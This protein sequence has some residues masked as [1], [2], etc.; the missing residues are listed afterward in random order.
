M[1]ITFLDNT[2]KVELQE[3]ITNG[4]D[5]VITSKNLLEFAKLYEGYNYT[6]ANGATKDS[7]YDYF[8]LTLPAYTYKTN[9]NV[10]RVVSLELNKR[11]DSNQIFTLTKDT[12]I[13]VVRPTGE[14]AKVFKQEYTAAEVE[15]FGSV[16][17]KDS[18]LTPKIDEQLSNMTGELQEQTSEKIINNITKIATSNNLLEFAELIEGYSYNPDNGGNVANT[19]RSYYK[20]KLAADTYVINYCMSCYNITTNEWIFDSQVS[21]KAEF[22][23]ESESEIIVNKINTQTNMKLFSGTMTS[24]LPSE[25]ESLGT[26]TLSD[27]I[28]TPKIDEQF[29]N[30]ESDL[31]SL[32]ADNDTNDYL[33]KNVVTSKNLLN[34]IKPVEGYRHNATGEVADSSC[35][36]Y[37][38]KLATGNY[39]IAPQCYS[40]F[41]VTTSTA[42]FSTTTAGTNKNFI[43]Y[44]DSESEIVVNRYLSYDLKLYK[45]NDAVTEDTTI[46]ITPNEVESLGQFTLPNKTLIPNITEE[47]NDNV[48]KIVTSKNLLEFIKPVE[49]YRYTL[50]TIQENP[51]INY[52]RVKLP[53][54]N[55]EFNVNINSCLNLTNYGWIITSTN[56]GAGVKTFSLTEDAEV[57]INYDKN[58]K[59]ILFNSD[60][61]SLADVE[62][63]GT[64][65]LANTVIIP[66]FDY[67]KYIDSTNYYSDYNKTTG[68]CTWSTDTALPILYLGTEVNS[69]NCKDAVLDTDV[70]EVT[71]T[72]KFINNNVLKPEFS[73]IGENGDITCSVKWQGSSSIKYPKK[74]YTIKFDTAFELVDGWGTEKKYC[75]KANFID[76]SQSRNIVAAGLW[77]EVV[78]SRSDKDTEGTLSN[79]LSQLP[80]GGAVDGFPFILV[81]GDEYKG[82]YTFNIPKDGW[83]FGMGDGEQECILCAENHL[84][85]EKFKATITASDAEV[86]ITKDDIENH[87][88]IEYNSDSFATVDIATSL[89]NLLGKCIDANT[90]TI[91]EVQEQITGEV[92]DEDTGLYVGA[93][94][95]RFYKDSEG[96]LGYCYRDGGIDYVLNQGATIDELDQYV[97]WQS[98]ID[99][100]I[101]TVLIKGIDITDKNYLLSTFDGTQWFFSAYDLDSI[102]GLRYYGEK[103]LTA[104]TGV[105]FAAYAATHNLMR[106]IKDE[107]R[108]ELV[109]RYKELRDTVFSE[110]NIATMFANFIGFIPKRVY[111]SDLDLWR[112]PNS[113]VN[114]LNQITDWYRRRVVVIDK[115]IEA[116]E[117][118]ITQD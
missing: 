100:Y 99:Y 65:T 101:F 76:A 46:N 74:N 51:D 1:A 108:A 53:K 93:K 11:I 6:G 47:I 12:D 115:E 89:N 45:I 71:T 59:L 96:H 28:Q 5:K 41:N 64:V 15:T 102:F 86:G 18:V 10:T 9:S 103:I 30:I 38:I 79:R 87:F 114:N 17:L 35:S 68:T 98:A 39:K 92:L 75:I 107:K 49:G 32:S 95:I 73:Q 21:N 94:K 106:L 54:G 111:D 118:T 40:C 25:I 2:D 81:I 29:S 22:T 83:M 20:L 67:E 55:Y 19:N 37:K 69:I 60:K 104:N 42:I 85:P 43:F 3:Q 56:A 109:K 4:I 116:L 48:Q 110:D 7:A 13:V 88:S 82:V 16:T 90:F 61:Y 23:L 33:I 91:P 63:I 8:T 72:C 58:A 105:T 112:T 77:G 78:K 24:P 70:K 62:P 52:Y 27:N 36:Y 113:E 97:D 57:V 14:D 117:Q 84:N 44:L 34:F 31:I 66:G 50:T 26:L 80:N